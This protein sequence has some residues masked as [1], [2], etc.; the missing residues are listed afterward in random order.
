MYNRTKA[1]ALVGEHD[2][3]EWGKAIDWMW[4]LYYLPREKR[5]T[6]WL[7]TYHISSSTISDSSWTRQCNPRLDIPFPATRLVLEWLHG[8]LPCARCLKYGARYQ[9]H[10]GKWSCKTCDDERA[11]ASLAAYFARKKS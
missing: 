9:I 7:K 3:V 4:T 5:P 2:L 11:S 8:S 10:F 6:S 1:V